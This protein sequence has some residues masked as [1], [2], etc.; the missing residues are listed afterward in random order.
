[1]EITQPDDWH[2]HFRDGAALA[3]TVPA[4]ARQFRRAIAMPNLVPPVT[5]TKLALQYRKRIMD[6]VPA[7]N[8]FEPLMTL[9]MTDNT[10]PEEIE[11]AHASGK[12]VAV[13]LYPRGATTNSSSGVTDIS[14]LTPTL[15]KMA[16]LGILLL[17]HGEVTAAHVDIFDREA[18]FIATVLQPLVSL[19]PT[20]K[21]VLEHC[22]TKQ[23]VD[24]VKSAGPNVGATITP[25]HLLYN[26]NA[27]FQGGVNPHMYCLPILKREEHRQALLS[28]VSSGSPKFFLGTD[29]A[30]HA[31]ERKESSCGCAGT[32]SAL[33]ALELYAE[34]FESVQALDKF[35]GFASLNGAT[36]Y[37]LPLN[38]RK[39]RIER[40]EWIVPESVTFG[41]SVVVPLRGGTALSWRLK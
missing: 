11:K 7:G 41:D 29:S 36:F 2:H 39:I 10:S 28:A 12:V 37:G 6:H 34:A 31:K 33:A 18:E 8:E 15:E 20:L 26:R 16:S 17:I 25:Q 21:V 27:I 35:E 5:T 24:F 19:V 22:T 9:Y 23:A 30:P 32:F 3:T 4:A 13:K 14:K 40:E 38:T 1:M